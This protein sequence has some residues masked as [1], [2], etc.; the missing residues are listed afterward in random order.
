MKVSNIIQDYNI[1]EVARRDAKFILSNLDNY[2]F[3]QYLDYVESKYKENVEV[4]A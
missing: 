3:R 1:L 2:E 4:I